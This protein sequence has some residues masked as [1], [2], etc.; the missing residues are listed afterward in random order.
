M[1]LSSTGPQIASNSH[2]EQEFSMLC[3]H[4][5]QVCIAYINTLLIQEVLVQHIPDFVLTFEDKRGLTP[6]IYGYINPFSGLVCLAHK[7]H[8]VF[9]N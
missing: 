3:L 9:L 6:L 1:P 7:I 2:D 4:L 5:L 8:M